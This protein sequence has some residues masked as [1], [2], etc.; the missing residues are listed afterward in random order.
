MLNR[1]SGL[2]GISGLS[3]DMRTLAAAAEAGHVRAGL[4]IDIFCYRLAKGLLGLAAGL[5]RIDAL[6]F[7]GGI[8]EHSAAVRAKTLSHLQIL[9]PVIDAE[10]N[11]IHGRDSD[12]RITASTSGL[13]TLVVPTNEELVIAREAMRFLAPSVTSPS[14]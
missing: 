14:S 10:H 12:G 8:G 7:T 3:N 1:E 2:L 13:L 5:D 11:R 6:V 4:A 9:H